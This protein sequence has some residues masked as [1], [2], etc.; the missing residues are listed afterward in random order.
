MTY[1]FVCPH[2]KRTY[3]KDIRMSDYDTEK[4]NQFCDDDKTKLERIFEPFS[5]S[6]GS[7]GGYDSV[8][9]KASWQH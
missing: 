7:T 4:N 2:C 3:Q 5:G 1:V 9:G 8:R 6:I